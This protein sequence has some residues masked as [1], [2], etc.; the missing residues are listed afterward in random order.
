MFDN[1]PF[2]PWILPLLA[3]L[4]FI[5]GLGAVHLFD[6]DEV[7][8]AEISREMIITKDYLRVYVDFL[9]F[10]EKPPLFFWLQSICMRLFGIG[11]FAARLPNALCG[12]LTLP[13]LYYMG[14]QLFH[15]RMGWLWAGAYFGSILPHLYFR[16]GII[17]P[18]FNLFIFTGLYFV[19]LFHW[20]KNGYDSIRLNL[21]PWLYLFLGGLIVGLGILTKG[22][23][24][25]F[26]S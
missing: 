24:A 26:I 3:V 22:P 8:F 1:R 16:S 5:P 7:N 10:W 23:V 6:W 20:K 2:S 19:I 13:L 25:F 11:E 17:D 9:P 4:F 15:N 21:S 18:W 12:I 14:K